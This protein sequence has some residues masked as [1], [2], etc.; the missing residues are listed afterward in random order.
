MNAPGW[1]G[2]APTIGR[3]GVPGRHARS[4]TRSIMLSGSCSAAESEV[5][6]QPRRMVDL[7][8][9]GGV[10]GLVLLS[11]WPDSHVVLVD[12]NDRRTEFLS[13]VVERFGMRRGRRG[14]AGT[15]RGC[16]AEPALRGAF[17]PGHLPVV[18]CSGGRPQSAERHFWRRGADGRL[19]ASGRDLEA[20]RWPSTGLEQLGLQPSTRVRFN[21]IASGTRFWSSRD[22]PGALPAAGRHPDKTPAVLSWDL[23]RSGVRPEPCFTWNTPNASNLTD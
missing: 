4:R 3:A 11:C 12:S 9:G 10:P 22:D 18:R 20:N 15:G 23:L 7:G 13:D 8:S 17:R 21:E 5:G 16:W 6:P 1:T 14:A 2:A 19:R